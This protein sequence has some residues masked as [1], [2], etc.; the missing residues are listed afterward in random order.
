MLHNSPFSIIF[1]FHYLY[2]SHISP[3]LKKLFLNNY[4]THIPFFKSCNYVTH[5]TLFK[6]VTHLPI[7]KKLF[8]NNFVT[9]L[10]FSNYVTMLHS[11]PS[12]TNNNNNL[13]HF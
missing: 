1:T 10:P 8:L 12:S 5:L 4:V 9:H 2:I 13:I 7:F 6:N 3:L 11:S